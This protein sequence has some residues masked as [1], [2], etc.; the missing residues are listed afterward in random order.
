MSR[1][2]LQKAVILIGSFLALFVIFRSLFSI[3]LPFLLGSL[4]ALAAEKPSHFLQ[5]KFH[6]PRWLAAGVSVSAVFV[7]SLLILLGLLVIALRQLGVFSHWLPSAMQALQSGLD[8][9]R[10]A[11]L[12]LVS[13]CSPGVSGIVQAKIA[14]WFSDSAAFLTRLSEILLNLA[15]SLLKGIP[16]GA[17]A[18]G[19]MLISSYMI[20]SKL[21]HIRQFLAQWLSHERQMRCLSAW[22]AIR[23][24]VLGYLQAQLKLM[25]ITFAI[26]TVGLAL[27]RIRFAPLWAMLIA[28]VDAAPLLGTGTVMVPWALICLLQHNPFRCIGLLATYT[29][30]AAARSALEPRLL[31]RQMGIDP[32]LTLAA[33]Y[34]GYRLWGIPG[35]FLSPMIAATALRLANMTVQSHS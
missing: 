19:T 13:R 9:L 29:A 18:F 8:T 3:L 10:D 16:D 6:F 22:K 11:L 1:T 28:L 15:T 25:G 5:E 27:L 14:G 12:A 21:P 17:L 7:G 26:I 24:S 20:C 30:A 35:M 32:L 33:L 23:I 34:L 4:L 2:T 31:G